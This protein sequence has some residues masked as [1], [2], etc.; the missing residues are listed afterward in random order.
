VSWR[1]EKRIGVT[2]EQM[3]AAPIAAPKTDLARNRKVAL[4][5]EE[6]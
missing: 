4:S 3:D 2:F 5:N 1:K 6:T